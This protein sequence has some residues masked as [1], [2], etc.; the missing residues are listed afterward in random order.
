MTVSLMSLLGGS[1]APTTDA[2][3]NAAEKGG[4]TVLSGKQATPA[5]Q[6]GFDAVLAAN[7]LQDISAEQLRAFFKAHG[8]ALPAQPSGQET[9]ND[10]LANVMAAQDGQK[11]PGNLM[12]ELQ[13]ML[14]PEAAMASGT[15]AGDLFA[16]LPNRELTPEELSELVQETGLPPVVIFAAL[17]NT[18]AASP[19]LAAA[20]VDGAGE[21]PANGLMQPQQNAA[22]QGQ[23][24]Q[25][26]QMQAEIAKTIAA[27]M[28]KGLSR[29]EAT[30][31][32]NQLASVDFSAL[33][34]EK[35]DVLKRI[36]AVMRG[37]KLQGEF[38]WSAQSNAAN[39]NQSAKTQAGSSQA[40]AQED[41]PSLLQQSKGDAEGK[42]NPS[43][44]AQNSQAKGQV[45][46]QQLLQQAA[47][48]NDAAPKVAQPAGETTGNQQVNFATTLE[49]STALRSTNATPL[50]AQLRHAPTPQQDGV[51]EQVEVRL[52]NALAD[53]ARRMEIHLKP[54]ELGRVD[55]RIDTDADGRSHVTVTADKRDTLDMLQRDARALE[56]AL[57]EA[58]LKADSNNLSFNLRGEDQQQAKDGQ[59]DKAQQATFDINGEYADEMDAKLD[60]SEMA[61]TYDA[62][63]AYRLNLD[64]GVDISV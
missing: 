18:P 14:L 26:A 40:T 51:T 39:S 2:L 56:R 11:L 17:Q 7:D 49:Q 46:Q 36:A 16:Q 25:D 30:Q 33:H 47:A 42:A 28:Q 62:G 13:E 34:M 31:L 48:G 45:E 9:A 55:V 19:N 4:L 29:E 3:S 37:E 1:A 32:S 41:G 44:Q 23:A 5:G 38:D 54:A 60:T 59:K 35:T 27:L 24:T 64:W 12:M 52:R 57:N 8:I 6:N 22:A 63:R 21:L 43:L 58:G 50:D 10:V 20:M 53:G 61:L 15:E